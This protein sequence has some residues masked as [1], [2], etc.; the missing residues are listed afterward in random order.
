MSVS[1]QST[2]RLGDVRPFSP[3]VLSDSEEYPRP[4]CVPLKVLEEAAELV[5]ASKLWLKSDDNPKLRADML[6]EMADVL[7]TV[8]NQC[9]V[10]HIGEDEL[11]EA[12]ARCESR[13]RARGRIA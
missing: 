13:N 2:I 8:A 11:R 12:V 6:D 5:E 7:Q 3:R 1:F 10:F 4:K 9:A